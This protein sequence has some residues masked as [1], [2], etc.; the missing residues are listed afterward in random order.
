M[1][2]EVQV[3]DC[4]RVNGAS[5]EECVGVGRGFYERCHIVWEW[6]TGWCHKLGCLEVCKCA[7]VQV[8]DVVWETAQVRKDVWS[9]QLQ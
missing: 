6:C 7:S 1:I 9:M 4:M 8:R 5:Q 3:G 2:H